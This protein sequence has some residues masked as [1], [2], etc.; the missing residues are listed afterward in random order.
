MSGKRYNIGILVANIMDTFSNRVAKGAIVAAKELD[1]NLII[2][3]MKYLDIDYDNIAF[4]IKFEYQYNILLDYAA[5]AKLDYLIVCTG[6]IAYISDNV[7]KKEILDYLSDTPVLNVAAITEGYDYLVYDNAAGIIQ[8]VDHLV[9]EQHRKHICMMIGRL[10]N[11]ECRERFNA[12]KAALEANG[13]EFSDRMAIESDISEYCVKEA[14]ELLD[15]NPECDAVLCVNDEMAMVFYD[16]LRERGKLIG[17]DIML[18]GFDDSPFAAKMDPPLASVRA[19]AYA[20]GHRA[21][22]KVTNLLNGI[23][24]TD[25]FCKTEFIP[26]A[27]CSIASLYINSVNNVF[28]G[29]DETIAENMISY[30]YQGNVHVKAN[31][32]ALAFCRSIVRQL[33]TM[34]IDNKAD[35]D[36]FK[37][38]SGLIEKFFMQNRYEMDLVPRIIEIVDGGHKWLTENAP[39]ENTDIINKLFKYV[40]IK[41][42]NGIISDYK[43]YED[44]FKKHTHLSN[45]FSRDTLM[46][47]EDMAI[48]YAQLMC[49]FHCLDIKSSYLFLL[50]EPAEYHNNGEFPSGAQWRFMSHQHWEEYDM[51]PKEERCVSAEYMY[52]NKYI[53]DYE[54]H[55]FIVA[56]LYSRE[57][58][59]GILLCEPYTDKFF[60][61]LE[62][63]V[64][65][66]SAAVKL[67]KFISEQDRINEKLH[68][69]NIALEN[70]SEIDE[71][72]GIYN[73]RGFYRAAEDFIEK[74]KGRD[75]IVCYAD[76]DGLK[77]VNDGYGHSE[78]D[79][80]IKSLAL[81]LTEAFGKNGIVGRM[82]GDEFAAFILKDDAGDID[83]IIGKKREYIERLNRT[84][85]KPYPIDMSMGFC[86][87]CCE[88]SY[89]F[90][91]AVDKAD[92][93][94]YD[95]KTE[96]K[97]RNKRSAL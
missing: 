82:G 81:C 12:Y 65:Q 25:H 19:D 28:K 22:E 37:Y 74:N 30:I 15:R 78:G 2:F 27:S 51:V 39:A 9:K 71:L 77:L 72:T 89:D 17:R 49:K 85:N 62:L 75:I 4:D 44:E 42:S 47:N 41:I 63:V 29:D 45:I 20:M 94:L 97:R 8:A 80:S 56:D 34:I 18:V 87:C 57:Y 67:I 90:K 32:N 43:S 21:V 88:N 7:R 3:P 48:S 95:D 92:G 38:L 13:L 16:I 93:K 61:D 40:V 64:Y 35:I 58:Q 68:M 59:Y 46:F 53:P 86:E 5:K 23:E 31:E 52:K 66:V 73:R 26:R 84:A 6:T 50:D 55:I 10:V 33:K 24:D 36:A 1:V 69:K 79:F 54:Q 76:M 14:N 11:I 96:R 91:E 83:S 60:A 70:L